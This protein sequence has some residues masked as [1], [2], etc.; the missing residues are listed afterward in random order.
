MEPDPPGPF[1]ELMLRGEKLRALRLMALADEEERKIH[2]E[3]DMV[4]PQYVDADADADAEKSTSLQIPAEASSSIVNIEFLKGDFRDNGVPKDLS[5]TTISTSGA[6]SRCT[7]EDK[8]DLLPDSKLKVLRYES[9]LSHQRYHDDYKHSNC[10]FIDFKIDGSDQRIVVEQQRYL[11]KGGLV[12]DAG[13]IL[14][15]HVIAHERDWKLQEKGSITRVVDLGAGVG[16]T[17]IAIA[18]SVSDTHVT[19]TDLPELLPLMKRNVERNFVP[20]SILVDDEDGSIVETKRYQNRGEAAEDIPCH[21]D[22]G[23]KGLS[24]KDNCVLYEVSEEIDMEHKL[25]KASKGQITAAVLRWGVKEDYMKA[26]YDVI[27]AADVVASLYS[28]KALAET[29]HDLCRKETKVYISLKKRLT[30][31]LVIFESAMK[32]LF[33]TVN[34]TT[35]VSRRKLDDIIIIEATGK[36]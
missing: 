5:E 14:A 25:M 11:G 18:K 34:Y 6:S 33:W 21:R 1:E 13:V 8:I 7:F 2:D 26:P 32:D 15:E 29:I 19:I 3:L 20:D 36:R 4:L 23:C 16:F 24:S 10:D 35:P 22:K 9:Y 30:E 31:P 28:P 17:G 27:V 12:W